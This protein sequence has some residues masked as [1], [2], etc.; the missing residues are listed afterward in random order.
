MNTVRAT[1]II[2]T[3]GISIFTFLL[4]VFQSVSGQTYPQGMVAYWKFDEGS[5][6]VARDLVGGHD[7][8]IV[9]AQWT[10][11]QVGTALRFDRFDHT[12]CGIVWVNHHPDLNFPNNE[13]TFEAWVNWADHKWSDYIIISKEFT[14]PVQYDELRYGYQFRLIN[15]ALSLVICDGGNYRSAGYLVAP[16][17]FPSFTWHHVVAVYSDAGDFARLYQDGELI[18]ENTSFTKSWDNSGNTSP[19]TIGAWHS[20]LYGDVCVWKGDI[21]EVAMYNRVL[22]LEEI[23]QHYQNGLQGR[24]YECGVTTVTIDVKP[25]SYPNT[26]NPKSKG[27]IPVAILTTAT[28]DATTVDPLSVKFGPSGAVESHHKGHIEDADGDGDMDMVLHFKTQETG[29]QCG[30]TQAS[31]TGET[32]GG[33]AITGT[34]VIQTVG[35]GSQNPTAGLKLNAPDNSTQSYPNPFNPTTTIRYVLPVASH[36]ILIVYNSLGE[37]VARLVDGIQGAGLKL[38]KFDA[39]GLPSGVYF[40]RL[41]AGSFTETKKLLLLR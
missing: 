37:E 12:G 18:A 6:S 25:E 7:G 3:K 17:W 22:T 16:P 10:S 28:F 4:L 11:G 34:D 5:G 39:S 40:Y 2:G 32:F 30:E 19:L 24:G 13:V 31:L 27:V 41:Q 29:I 38:A 21:D 20:S 35:C 15:A 8:V 33:Q 9:G 26:I 23:R 1:S 14:D 36:V